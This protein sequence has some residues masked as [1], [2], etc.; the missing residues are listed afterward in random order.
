MDDIITY[1]ALINLVIASINLVIKLI[2]FYNGKK[3]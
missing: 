3:K 2:E 1:I